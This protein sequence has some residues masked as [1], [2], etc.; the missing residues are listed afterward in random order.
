[1]PKKLEKNISYMTTQMLSNGIASTD[2]AE[3]S[4]GK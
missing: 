2:G 1:M 3:T 4:Q